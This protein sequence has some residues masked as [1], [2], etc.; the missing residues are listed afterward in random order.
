LKALASATGK[1][2]IILASAGGLNRDWYGYG[3]KKTP[4]FSVCRYK[5]N[6]PTPEGSSSRSSAQPA[7]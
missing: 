6:G 7:A 4:M 3:M 1:R 2:A 5:E